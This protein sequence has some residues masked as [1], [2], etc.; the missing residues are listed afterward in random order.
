MVSIKGFV[1]ASASQHLLHL[2][3]MRIAII[4]CCVLIW[5]G[6][7]SEVQAQALVGKV[8]DDQG[9]LLPGATITIAPV[10]EPF[11]SALIGVVTTLDGTYSADLSP[12]SGR[13]VIVTCSY[14]GLEKKQVELKNL[15]GNAYTLDWV[16]AASAEM[17][18]QVVVSA[19][20]FEQSAKKVTVSVDVLPPR[21]IESRGTTS[22]ETALEQN[23]GV[24]F[25]DGEPQIR[26][27]SG[28]S[29]GA[30]SRVM[31]L[32]D[33]LP[34]LS[35]DAGRPTWGF[36]PLENIEQIEI[37]KGAS[38]VM[39][40]SA[41][42]SGVINI[43]TRYPDARPL[44]RISVQHGLYSTPQSAQAKTW[45]GFG[46]QSNVRFVHSQ[47]AGKWDVVVAG[48][49]LGDDGFLSPLVENETDTASSAYRPWIV[50]RYGAENRARVNANIRRR[51]TG[52]AGL[53]YGLNTNWQRGES[54]N[55]LIWE[56]A[57]DHI[58]GSYQGAT[59]HVNQTVG[60]VDPYIEYAAPSGFR[61][62]VRNRWQYLNNDNDNDQSNASH[63]FYS[64]Y[65]LNGHGQNWGLEGLNFSAGLV[66][67]LAFSNAELYSGGSSDGNNR[68]R[69]VAAYLQVDQS[70][71]E[72][73]NVSAGMRYEHFEVNGSGTGKP[74]FRAGVN[75]QLAEA[76][77][78]RSS[79]GQGFRFPTIAERYIRTGLGSLQVY[80]NEELNPEFATS[81]EIGL[82]Q[83]VKFGRFQGF[84]DMAVFR[85]D[86]DDYIEFTFGQWGP[87]DGEPPTL[88][89]ALGL[90]FKSINTGKSRV[91]GAEISTTGRIE[92]DRARFDIIAGYTYTR[93]I[94]L[95]PN[96]NYNPDS[97]GTVTTYYNTSHDTTNLI[98]KYRSPHLVRI[99]VQATGAK[100][101]GGVS[102][103]Y[104]SKL[105]NFDEAFIL[106]EAEDIADIE[107]GLAGWLDSHPRS[108]WLVDVRI[109]R[110]W[111][112][113]HRLSLIV[114]NLAN[115][116][117]VIRPLAIEQ[118]RLT[119]IMYTYEIK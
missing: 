8:A 10:N 50:D 45:D 114:S 71:A 65:Q 106:F 25:V 22:L 103:R 60:T 112:E 85:Q 95:T 42:L 86:F 105:Q 7:S 66:H 24:S 26:S 75:Y 67:L 58:Y 54:Q 92:T 87:D 57:P 19:G 44:T 73:L 63:V 28:F 48:N 80:P 39:Y 52:V 14:I 23:P 56:S 33:D 78:L 6:V 31:M 21:I 20:R 46:Q 70:F 16:L 69:N 76:T 38:S 82:K 102:V 68:G 93:P 61:H 119:Q 11:S 36:L 72:R 30:G 88:E 115:S 83:G 2:A 17:L 77:Y 84:L 117:Y 37:I 110:Q 4:V 94:S 109:G 79:F 12:L 9:L 101:F 35:G 13:D 96:Y 15:Q 107:W 113:H 5:F 111:N 90:G 51:E 1:R 34:V 53:T 118:P 104:Q 3:S 97:T 91:T 32:V 40:G 55:T 89:N 62:A 18:E 116:E 43:R 49:I 74:V 59:T 81:G 64:E 108:P 29:Y 27:G 41:A 98:L 100:W 99:D 47:R